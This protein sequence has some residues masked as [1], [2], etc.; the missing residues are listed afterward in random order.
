MIDRMKWNLLMGNVC[1][2]TTGTFLTCLINI[3]QLNSLPVWDGWSF[4]FFFISVWGPWWAFLLLH[5]GVSAF[6]HD[7]CGPLFELI[8]SYLAVISNSQVIEPLI[9]TSGPFVRVRV[10]VQ[11]SRQTFSKESQ[12]GLKQGGGVCAHDNPTCKQRKVAPKLKHDESTSSPG[13]PAT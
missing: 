10:S 11:K 12:Q 9:F 8:C 4:V 2:G 3:F 6:M 7:T 13:E 1:C 5:W